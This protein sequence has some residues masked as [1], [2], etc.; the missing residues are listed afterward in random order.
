MNITE[1]EFTYSKLGKTTSRRRRHNLSLHFIYYLS[2][3]FVTLLH[4]FSFNTVEAS[5]D[6]FNTDNFLLRG[7]VYFFFA[8]HITF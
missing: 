5:F 6:F 2:Y 7:N 3:I 8:F 4:D 1:L